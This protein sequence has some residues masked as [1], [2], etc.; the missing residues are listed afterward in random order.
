V[1]QLDESTH[2]V[3]I[4]DDTSRPDWPAAQVG[5]GVFWCRER[6]V[7]FF[8]TDYQKVFG[9][10]LDPGI[11]RFLKPAL[12][13]TYSFDLQEMKVPLINTV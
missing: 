13:Y 5:A 7:V 6:G 3:R 11:G 12:S 9:L 8:Q 10:Q 1:Q 2:A 4:T